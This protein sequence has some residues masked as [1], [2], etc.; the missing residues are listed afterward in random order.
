MDDKRQKTLLMVLA[1]MGLG[2]GGYFV[3]L[4]DSGASADQM[5]TG[6]ATKRLKRATTANSDTSGR[7]VKRA[8]VKRRSSGPATR[9]KRATTAAKKTERV[10]RG[11]GKR[12][13][14]KK[15]KK[16]APAA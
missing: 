14:K 16:L 1:V 5:N 12:A 2:A 11:V 7:R 8:K 6:V 10:K 15:K 13:V 3:F 9:A 4:R